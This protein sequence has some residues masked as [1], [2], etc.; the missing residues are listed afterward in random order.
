MTRDEAVQA[1]EIGIQSALDAADSG[2][3][4]IAVGEVV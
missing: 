3:R 2:Y 1:I 4:M